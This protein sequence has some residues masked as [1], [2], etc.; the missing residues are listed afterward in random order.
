MPSLTIALVLYR[1]QAY[2]QQCLSSVLEQPYRDLE[3]VVVENASPDHGPEILAA[4][5]DRDRRLVVRHLDSAVS[6]GEARNLALESASGDYLWF[7][8]TTDFMPPDALPVVAEQ[9]EETAPDVLLVDHARASAI[10]RT[11]PVRLRDAF[12]AAGG[13]TAFTLDERP[14]VASTPPVVWDKVFSAEFLRT[15]DVRFTAGRF[16]ELSVV[17]PALLT[18]DRISGLDHVAYV[19]R[20][21]ANAADEPRVHGTPFDVF[22]QYD[23]V[24]GR[25]DSDRT[26]PA[27]RRRLLPEAML[28]HFL[29][30]FAGLPERRRE[31]FFVR[32][33]ESYRRHVRGDEPSPP[34]RRLRVL[35]GVVRRGSY[36]SFRALVWA[37]EQQRDVRRRVARARRRGLKIQ[38]ARRGDGLG[39]YYR[40]QLREPI[41][42]DLAVFA[43]YWYR[44]YSCN[45]RAIYEKLRELAPQIRS[46]WVVEGRY[47]ADMPSG[48]EYVVAG[49]RD[50]WSVLARAAYFVNNVN[51]PNEL[52][53]RE[54]TI[55]VQTHH[56][57]PLKKMGLDLRDAPIARQRT[58]FER[59]LR[60]CARWD[61]SISS[62]AFSTIIW[63]R[64]YPG[65]Y[66][67]LEVGYPRNDVLVNATEADVA[68]IREGLGI[69]PG[70]H[71]VLYA[72]TH[73]EYLDGPPPTADVGRLAHE[74]GSD[75]VIMARM[76][77]FY[78]R[79]RRFQELQRAGRILDVSDHGSVE[80]LCL[81]A[82][83]LLTDYS[84]IMF[85]YA[86]LDRPI[87]I[88]AADWDVYRAMRGTY[89]DLLSEAPGVVTTTDDELVEAIRSGAVQSEE[90]D[91][92]RAAFRARF[93]SLEDGHAAERVVRKVWLSDEASARAAGARD[94]GSA[95]IGA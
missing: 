4:L 25:A 10:G 54:G 88:Y 29:S 34:S 72:P 26:L 15:L 17:Y 37:V 79:E 13:N 7:V 66:E 38:P 35:E 8:E 12:Q 95:R 1:E 42:P 75:F 53:K 82:D 50:Y 31:E 28:R 45:P 43:S 21:P 68:R 56:G 49:T 20:E 93:C 84:A 74:L 16:G 89:F 63:E 62:N 22:D 81:A 77:Y 57:T 67:S 27:S 76:H 86:V 69:A 59:L 5:A 58:N 18:A 36:R 3:L 78:G 73:R 52:V 83:S 80:E 85:D 47:A 24:F 70:Q 55:H 19:R 40:S 90:A 23:A 44:G 6:V 48:V 94:R 60:R 2:L 41:E 32:M 91:G 51:F 30:V 39:R 64:V 61:Y 87:V 46:V 65:R 92:R 9:L 14:E 33:S 71:A 11:R